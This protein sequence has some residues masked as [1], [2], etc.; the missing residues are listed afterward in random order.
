M[1][2]LPRRITSLLLLC[3][4]ALSVVGSARA[5]RANAPDLLAAYDLAEHARQGRYDLDPR[6]DRLEITRSGRQ[7]TFSYDQ[8]PD[9]NGRV[10]VGGY[11]S[12]KVRDD[13]SV[14]VFFGL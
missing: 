8:L 7:W 2:P 14:N 13:G 9:K 1:S 4:A 12:V 3:L 11:S 5:E 10:I 6:S